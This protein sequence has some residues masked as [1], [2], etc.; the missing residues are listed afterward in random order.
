MAGHVHHAR[1]FAEIEARRD[2][3]ER[4]V[5]AA[6]SIV[7]AFSVMTRLPPPQT[8]S[9]QTARTLLEANFLD[10]DA[11]LVALTVA[12][13]RQLIVDASQQGTAGGR[14]YDAAIIAC[15]VSAGVPVI[16]TFNERH[17]RDLARGRV[18]IVVPA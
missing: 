7:E 3:S 12:E 14:V 8:L 18:E 9:P 15:A 17:F 10:A 6:H 13:Y 1:A 5:V 2:R 11:D 16:L 4:L